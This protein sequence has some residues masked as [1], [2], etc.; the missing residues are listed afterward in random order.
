V[1]A[2]GVA[3]SSET[4]VAIGIPT[5]IISV[6]YRIKICRTAKLYPAVQ[7]W[8]R[9]CYFFSVQHLS[10]RMPEDLQHWK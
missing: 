2:S 9:Q 1:T 5:S 8:F 3:T 7:N 6:L 4:K 10:D